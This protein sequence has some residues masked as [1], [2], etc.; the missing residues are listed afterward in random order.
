MYKSTFKKIR[1]CERIRGNLIGNGALLNHIK[2]H[3][4]SFS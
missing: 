4:L 3:K 2:K 1:H